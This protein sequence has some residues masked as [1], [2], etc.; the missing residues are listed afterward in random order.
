MEGGPSQIDTFDPKPE[1]DKV[2]GQLFKRE[3]VKTNQVKGSRYFVRSPF[4]FQ[5]YGHSGLHVSELFQETAAHADD[6]AL[7][8]SGYCDS[9]NHPAAI[10]QYTTGYPVQG[11]PSVGSWVVYGLG[12]ENENLPGFITINPPAN[13]GTTIPVLGAA[14]IR[15]LR[16]RGFFT[17]RAEPRLLDLLDLLELNSAL[18]M[19]AELGVPWM[20]MPGAEVGAACAVAVGGELVVDLWGGWRDH[21]Q[22]L[23]QRVAAAHAVD[24]VVGRVAA[25]EAVGARRPDERRRGVRRD[26]DG[27][28]HVV[29]LLG[30]AHPLAVVEEVIGAGDD[31][32]RTHRLRVVVEQAVDERDALGRLDDREAHPGLPDLGPPD[33]TGPHAHVHAGRTTGGRGRRRGRGTQPFRLF[34]AVR[35]FSTQQARGG[36]GCLSDGH[37]SGRCAGAGAHAGDGRHGARAGSGRPCQCICRRRHEYLGCVAGRTSAEPAVEVASQR[38]RTEHDAVHDR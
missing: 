14:L 33:A 15:T 11:H 30:P 9:D 16:T 6:L 1:L 28:V 20:P 13:A 27:D 10:F 19:D 12:T 29:G 17:K 38:R 2:D 8:R 3:N 7:L 18:P 34:D 24:D 4:K 37:L 31:P 35:L 23:L 25:V 22:G 26:V 21:A 32:V 36:D 5:Q